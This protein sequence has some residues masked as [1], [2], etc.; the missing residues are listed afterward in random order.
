MHKI[1]VIS[2]IHGH[3][4]ELM[5]LY[6]KVLKEWNFQPKKDILITLGDVNDGGYYTRRVIT[7]LIK[8]EKKYPHWIF[9]KGNHEDLMV[10]GKNKPFYSSEFELWYGQGG[11]A[12]ALSYVP[13]NKIHQ[14]LQNRASTNFIYDT[15]LNWIENRP[16]F[17]KI[18][19][20][21]FVHGGIDPDLGLDTSSFDMLW[22]REPFISSKK[23]FGFK[24]VFGHTI[25]T[26]ND[27]KRHLRPLEMANKI[28]I[29]TMALNKGRLTALLLPEEKFLFQESLTIDKYLW[30]KAFY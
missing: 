2:D 28:G 11:K 5:K 12:T 20:Y 1:V 25:F 27:P 19:D 6:D 24:V 8:W 15:H 29:D 18:D 10:K 17:H 22:M 3:Y 7:Q 9:L 30:N 14:Y 26:D 23:D 4:H 21:L 16:V 13:K